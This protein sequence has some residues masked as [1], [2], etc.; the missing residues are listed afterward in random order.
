MAPLAP[1]LKPA[2][3]PATT[4]D[5]PQASSSSSAVTNPYSPGNNNATATNAHSAGPAAS[6]EAPAP[7]PAPGA[8]VQMLLQ[9]LPLTQQPAA[10]SNK[11]GF[12][13]VRRRPWG[14]FAAE[15]RDATC[16]SR[17]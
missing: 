4:S 11:L 16:N 12:R 8:T 1:L 6:A 7:P 10:N 14:S 2:D 9:N 13:G 15:I 5:Q 17:R 3:R